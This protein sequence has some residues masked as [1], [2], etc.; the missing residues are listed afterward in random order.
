MP[1]RFDALG[2]SF[3]YPENWTLDDSDAR[4][5]RR[6]V[7]VYSPEG[8]FWS[9]SIHPASH[10]TEAIAAKIIKAMQEEYESL[11]VAEA[12]ETCSGQ[13]L[14]GYDLAFYCLDLTNTATIRIAR[15]PQYVYAIYCQA[16]DR[17]YERVRNVFQAMTISMLNGL[18]G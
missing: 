4:L 13:E 17:E 18:D 9:V 11:E 1:L 12:T 14:R 6:S 7:T 15:T 2:I 8:A 16:E 3:Q 10:K 5:G